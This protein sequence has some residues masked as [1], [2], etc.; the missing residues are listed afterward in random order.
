MRRR[1]DAAAAGVLAQALLGGYEQRKGDE[2][3]QTAADEPIGESAAQVDITNITVTGPN[4]TLPML[5]TPL[6]AACP[7]S[8]SRVK[9][10]CWSRI[11][12]RAAR[13]RPSK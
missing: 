6:P 4:S 9:K 7:R 8:A 12:S 5:T 1:G 3:I 10:Y 11:K 13:K 2:A